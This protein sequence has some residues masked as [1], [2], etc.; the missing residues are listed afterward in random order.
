M[1][2]CRNQP[3]SFNTTKMSLLMSLMV[4]EQHPQSI[5]LASLIK[6]NISLIIFFRF[7]NIFCST[8]YPL[9]PV[10]SAE[11]PS[12]LTEF[13]FFHALLSPLV[14]ITDNGEAKRRALTHHQ[15]HIS[16]KHWL[17]S[18]L[19]WKITSEEQLSVSSNLETRCWCWTFCRDSSSELT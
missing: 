9:C 16:L 6:S 2:P 13:I 4:K 12:K 8:F 18:C 15:G 7:A 11:P 19:Q 3:P 5:V 10:E 1:K 14:T 17:E